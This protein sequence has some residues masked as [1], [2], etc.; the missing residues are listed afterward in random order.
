LSG[1]PMPDSWTAP[2]APQGADPPMR[3]ADRV[4]P[5]PTRPRTSERPTGERD[6]THLPPGPATTRTSPRAPPTGEDP[7]ARQRESATHPPQIYP[8]TTN[9]QDRVQA[10]PDKTSTTASG[11]PPA[12]LRCLRRPSGGPSSKRCPLAGVRFR[13][14]L[15]G[16]GCGGVVFSRRR[17][18]EAYQT[19]VGCRN[20]RRVGVGCRVVFRSP[21][22]PPVR[23]LISAAHAR[24][25]ENT[26]PPRGRSA[27]RNWL[28]FH[29]ENPSFASLLSAPCSIL[30]VVDRAPTVKNYVGSGE[31]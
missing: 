12:V 29:A 24:R 21:V 30:V 20:R 22:A 7:P 13:G 15:V 11:W 31:P 1:E 3:C 8:P 6:Q 26:T 9:N 5:A 10:H 28:K 19:P 23:S 2:S 16:L 4:S 14:G 18:P 27:G 17:S 25:R